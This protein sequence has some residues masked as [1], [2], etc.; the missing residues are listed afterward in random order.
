MYIIEYVEIKIILK[1]HFFKTYFLFKSHTKMQIRMINHKF[2]I[3]NKEVFVPILLLF[4]FIF[5]Q[6]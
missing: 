2:Q 3:R 6:K 4:S 5:F 1:T